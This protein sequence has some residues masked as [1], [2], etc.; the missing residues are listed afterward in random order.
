MA[1]PLTHPF[2]EIIHT[3]SR[4]QA[5]ADG[6]LVD[7]NAL[8]DGDPN[9]AHE[10]GFRHPV[11]ITR[12]A[13][14]DTIAWGPTHGGGQDVTGRAWDVLTMARLAATRPGLDPSRRD[15]SVLRLAAGQQTPTLA[16]LVLRCGP[17]DDARP[18]LTI[19]L[20]DED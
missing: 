3:Y 10:Q 2:G 18:V 20:P 4:A 13:Y 1:A 6:E 14:L 16:A 11:A 12:A 17:G 15:F 9:L 5:L 7:L 8:P 19:T